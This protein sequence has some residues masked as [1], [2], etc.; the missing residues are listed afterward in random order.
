[1]RKIFVMLALAATA[2]GTVSANAAILSYRMAI[3]GNNSVNQAPLSVGLHTLTVEAIVT[4][5]DIFG[6]DGGILQSSFNLGTNNGGFIFRDVTGGFLNTPNG[7]WDSVS[8][9]N[10]ATGFDGRFQGSTTVTGGPTVSEETHFINPSNYNDKFANIAGNVY[11]VVAQGQFN[12]S[13]IGLHPA[14]LTLSSSP[15]ITLVSAF[16]G[17]SQIVGVQPSAVNG[18]TINFASPNVAPSVTP[19]GGSRGWR[20]THGQ[21]SH[22]F[23]FT[24]DNDSSLT[25]SIDSFTHNG[26]T[27]PVPLS[28]SIDSN[29][30]FTWDPSAAADGYQSVYTLTVRGTDSGLLSDTGS[31]TIVM[32]EPGTMVLAGFALVGFVTSRR[33]LS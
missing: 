7:T 13:G 17:V 26:L 25:W 2:L 20:S 9:V 28:Y 5:N 33:K 6:F 22:Q 32:P 8:F 23:N 14:S 18:Y 30:L 19:D 11:S 27:P 15:A 3:D 31:I 1:M 10:A 29:G 24:D 12:W 16:D 21:F 4:D